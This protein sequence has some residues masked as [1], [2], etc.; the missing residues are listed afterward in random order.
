MA[1]RVVAKVKERMTH[2]RV[3]DSLDKVSG[4]PIPRSVFHSCGVVL[5]VHTVEHPWAGFVN[6]LQLKMR[7]IH[8]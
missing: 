7:I 1:D 4:S 5:A 2:L 8:I 6:V 3:G